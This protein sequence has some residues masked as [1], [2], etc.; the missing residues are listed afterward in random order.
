MFQTMFGLKYSL[1]QLTHLPVG[2]G[3]SKKIIIQKSIDS[4][5]IFGIF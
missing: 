3:R 4:T 5:S 2:L 1:G